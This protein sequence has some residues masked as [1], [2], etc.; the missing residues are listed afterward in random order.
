MFEIQDYFLRLNDIR[1]FGIRQLDKLTGN[2]SRLIIKK[3]VNWVLPDFYR[4]HPGLQLYEKAFKEGRLS[5]AIVS[6]TSFPQRIDVVWLVVECL[7]RQ[8]RVP[9]KI[10]IYLSKEQFPSLQE[11]P[12]SLKQYP[13]DIVEIIFVDGD[14]R[15]HKKYW[16][17]IE[18][19]K[20]KPIILVDDDLVYDSHMIEDLENYSSK[21]KL[22]MA[23][24]WGHSIARN[25]DGKLL[26][27]LQWKNQPQLHIPSNY[28]FF[29][30]GGGTYFPEGS[31]DGAHQPIN[32]ITEICPY[33]DDIWLNAII[34]KNGYRPCLIRHYNSMPGWAI[35]NNK[36][37]H[38][39]N[40][41]TRHLNDA[42]I[43]NVREYIKS[44]YCFDP[45]MSE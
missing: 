4:A 34:R 22:V 19:Y 3:L 20:N 16:Y 42:Q 29:G 30:S 38:S 37:L 27:Y 10:L 43:M 17:V 31:L 40:N 24:C 28:L 35:K 13:K 7:L 12:E 9:A 26:P 2:G 14:I 6:M 25:A 33:A 45:F 15:S 23:C 39:I 21:E 44:N 8:T 11:V 5:N 32:I 41:G 18:E 36:T 1:P